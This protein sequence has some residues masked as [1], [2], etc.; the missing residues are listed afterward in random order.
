MAGG[1]FLRGFFILNGIIRVKKYR[2][3]GAP[4]GGEFLEIHGAVG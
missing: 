1:G 2:R 4:A 3:G